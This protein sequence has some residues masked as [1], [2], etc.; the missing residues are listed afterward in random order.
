MICKLRQ[1]GFRLDLRKKPAKIPGMQ[2]ADP[3]S[4]RANQSSESLLRPTSQF[5]VI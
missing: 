3:A 2:A 4:W 5:Y 1:E